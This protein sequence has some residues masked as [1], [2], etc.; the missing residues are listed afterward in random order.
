[1]KCHGWLKKSLFDIVQY[2]YFCSSV[3]HVHVHVYT[4]LSCE[5]MYSEQ[6]NSH[7]MKFQEALNVS[8]L[9]SLW[10]VIYLFLVDIP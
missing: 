7:K 3:L 8:K 2:I 1:M 5:V 6:E 10:Q 9:V 4:F